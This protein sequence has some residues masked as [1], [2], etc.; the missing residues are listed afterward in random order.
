MYLTP[1][2]A[3]SEELFIFFRWRWRDF[4]LWNPVWNVFFLYKNLESIKWKLPSS[5][6]NWAIDLGPICLV[7]VKEINRIT[8][9]FT[10]FRIKI[11]KI[12][13]FR[14]GHM[15][16]WTLYLEQYGAITDHDSNVKLLTRVP[17]WYTVDVFNLAVR[18]WNFHKA[19]WL[20]IVH[21][22]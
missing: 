3:P 9:D 17:T 11:P 4:C 6:L 15:N 10:F 5:W 2:M 7:A 22:K 14:N 8:V 19:N 20:I 18:Y 13:K 12:D 16:N 1:K 21:G